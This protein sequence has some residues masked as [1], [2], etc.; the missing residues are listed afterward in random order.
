V[1]WG[2]VLGLGVGYCVVC[3]MSYVMIMSFMI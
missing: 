3:C 1:G 2:W